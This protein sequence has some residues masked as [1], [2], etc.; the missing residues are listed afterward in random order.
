MKCAFVL[1]L[2]VIA[3]LPEIAFSQQKTYPPV[4]EGT[5]EHVYREVDDVQLKLWAFNPEGWKASDSRPAIVF[6]F[7][8]GWSG[9]NPIQFERHS[10]LLAERGMVA[11]VADYRVASRHGTKANECVEDARAAIRFLRSQSKILGIDPDRIAA[12]GGSAGGHIAACLGVIEADPESKPNAM[13]LYNPAC[14][15]APLDGMDYW[16]EDRYAE[17]EE[18]MGVKP[19]SLSPA[20]HVSKN[21]PPCIIFHGKADDTVPYATAAIFAEKMNALGVP[22]LLHGYEGEGHGFFN[23]GRESQSGGEPAFPKTMEQ[24]DAFF[25]DLGWLD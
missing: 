7:G 18:R 12:G 3:H 11:L 2:M 24:L 10:R 22:C 20:Q 1:F 23:D 21:A 5:K 6:F 13:A 25:I 14:V 9:G 8:G 19:E 16:P 4:I 17:M 15:I